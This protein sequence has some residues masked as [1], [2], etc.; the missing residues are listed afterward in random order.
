VPENTTVPLKFD[1]G[2]WQL[3]EACL[4][5]LSSAESECGLA[6][7]SDGN[8]AQLCGLCSSAL[9]GDPYVY[10]E[11]KQFQAKNVVAYGPPTVPTVPIDHFP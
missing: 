6:G 8:S 7:H 3:V 10:V 2:A 5:A 1:K 11:E 4:N 9:R